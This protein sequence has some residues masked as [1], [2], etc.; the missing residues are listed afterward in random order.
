MKETIL[1]IL[2]IITTSMFFGCNSNKTRLTEDQILINPYKTGQELIFISNNGDENR[3]T[4]TNVKRG[5]FA[6][7][8]GAPNNERLVV[9][10]FH[11]SKSIQGGKIARIFSLHAKTD[12][13]E[14]GL[15]FSFSMKDA[16]QR[17]NFEKVTDYN[18]RPIIQFNNG[19]EIFDDA[20]HYSEFTIYG[21]DGN[22]IVEFYWSQSHGYIRLIRGDGVVWNL[23]SIK[24]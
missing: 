13:K 5:V 1:F 24:N 19:Y 15:I 7:G 2:F 17:I 23:K 22:Q 8:I 18:S 12:K 14:S 10:A 20:I 4:I 9:E 21:N 16:Y 11:D 6:D 3:V